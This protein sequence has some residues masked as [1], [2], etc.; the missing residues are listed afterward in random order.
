MTNDLCFAALALCFAFCQTMLLRN[1]LHMFQL[2]SYKSYVQRKWVADNIFSILIRTV[3]LA[4]VVPLALELGSI[5][6]AASAAVF[7]AVGLLNLPKKAKKPLVLT[8]RVKRLVFTLFLINAAFLIL[9]ALDRGHRPDVC[10]VL[11][12]LGL[13]APYLVLPANVINSPVERAINRHYI[14]DAKR[15]L[16]EMPGL[17]VIGVTG[18]YGKTSMKMFLAG[19]L[20]EKFSVLPTPDSYNTTLGVVRTVRERLRPTHDIFICEMGARN[21]GDVKEICDIVRPELGVLTSI[22]PQHLESF[23]TIENVTKTKFELIDSLPENGVAVLNMD[24]PEIAGRRVP[25]RSV[26]YGLTA[27]DWR[28]LDVAVSPEGCSFTAA[29]PDGLLIPIRTRL[30]GAHNVLNILG[31]AA[32]AFE[33]GLTARE[34]SAGAARLRPVPHRLQLLGGAGRWV[35][36]D[37]YNSNPSGAAAAL[38]AL[39]DFK[40]LRILV[41]PGMV[42]LGD[43]QYELNRDFGLRAA[44]CCDLAVL[45]GQRQTR[46]IADGLKAGGMPPERVLVFETLGQAVAAADA[47]EP[48]RERVIL[49]ENDLPDNY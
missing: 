45:V 24:C 15:I 10:V 41:T 18:S 21:V 36:D 19:L 26:G 42:E 14:N 12:L 40:M 44:A 47:F 38:E 1:A 31:A 16:R 8:A 9:A 3:W 37:A 49:L 6:L 48:G 23:K 46:P 29:G 17:R 39:R 25:G 11:A 22:G 7:L 28:A 35:I 20:E 13:A 2:S 33:L 27:G 4:F 32:A 30:L 5:G 43:R 34:I